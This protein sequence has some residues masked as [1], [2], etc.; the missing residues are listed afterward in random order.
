MLGQSYEQEGREDAQAT[1]RNI[2]DLHDR[3]HEGQAGRD[4][5]VISAEHQ[6]VE[7]R[8]EQIHACASGAARR[9]AICR[10]QNRRRHVGMRGG[11]RCAFEDDPPSEKAHD[12]VGYS[13]RAPE[14]LLNQQIVVPASISAAMES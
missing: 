3:E 13:K 12:A 9:P 4:Q 1:M 7:Q 6:A 5:G 2:D 8:S 14:I 10:G 11:A